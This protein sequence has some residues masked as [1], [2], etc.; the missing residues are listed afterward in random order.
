M[1]WRKEIYNVNTYQLTFHC[2]QIHLFL[3]GARKFK[4]L[5]YHTR[6]HATLKSIQKTHAQGDQDKACKHNNIHF[7]VE[8]EPMGGG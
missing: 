5:T 4:F 7:G 8:T 6:I 2:E 1:F 3:S